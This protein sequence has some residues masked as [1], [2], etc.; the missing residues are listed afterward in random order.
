MAYGHITLAPPASTRE[1][2]ASS[3]AVSFATEHLLEKILGLASLLKPA[4]RSAPVV[5]AF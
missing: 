4:M 2:S 1:R 5:P 3:A